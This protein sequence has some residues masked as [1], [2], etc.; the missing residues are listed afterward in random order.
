MI[1]ILLVLTLLVGQFLLPVLPIDNHVH[2]ADVKA[3]TN[4]S[5]QD[6]V[7]LHCWNWSFNNIKANMAKIASLGYTA[8]QTSPI[9]QAK[10]ATKG[11]SANDWWVYYQPAAFAIDNTGNSAL[12]TKAEFKSMCETAHQYGIKVIVDVV[13]NHMGNGNSG[14][15]IHSNVIADLRNESSCWHDINTN[16][17]NYYDRYNITQYCLDGVPDLNTSSTKVQNYVLNYLKECVDAGA[18]GFR[19]DAVKHIETPQDTYCASN[20]WPNV[21]NGVKAYDPD[22]Y[23]YGEVLFNADEGNSLPMSAYTKYFPVTD[24]SWSNSVRNNVVNSNNAGA[25]SHS[26][27]KDASAD[28]LVLWAESHDNYAGD[29]T[30]GVSVTNINKTWALVAARADAMALYLARPNSLGSQK[31]GDASVTGW[32]YPEVAA[33]NKFHTA[34]AG[35]TEYVS[36][37]NN[38]A[39]VER[40]TSG[41]VLVNC[42]GTSGS[43]NVTANAMANGTYKDQI[44]GN[45]FTVSGG[46]ITGNIGSTGI[47]VVYNAVECNHESHS[48]GGVCSSCGAQVSH[49]FVG[50][51][52]TCSVCGYTK[53]ADKTIYFENTAGWS[54]VNIYTWDS[55]DNTFS[56]GWPGTAMTKVSGNIYSYTVSGE[57]E[58]VIFNNGT[59]QTDDLSIPSDADLY[60]Y[61]TGKWSSYNTCSHSYTSTVKAATCTAAGSTT[62]TCSKCGD[63]YSETIA[64]LGHSYGTATVTKQPTCAAAG[65]KTSTCG[66]CGDTKTES[67]AALGHSWDTGTVT[68]APTCSAAGVKTFT[69]GTCG[70]T[71]TESVASTDHN[72]VN[73]TCSACGASTPTNRTV[74]FDNTSNWSTVYI[75]Y[76]SDANSAMTTW[77]GKAMSKVSGSIYGYTIPLDAQYV[78]FNNNSGTQTGD[79]TLSDSK[80]LYTYSTSAW[81]SYA[82]C[83][84]PSHNT[85]GNCTSCGLAVGH[86]YVDNT[87]SVCGYTKPAGIKI[88]FD[89]SSKNWSTVYIYTWDDDNVNYSGSWPGSAMTN[90]GDGIWSYT[91]EAGAVNVIFNNNNGTQTG[92]LTIPGSGYIYNG[93][94]WDVYEVCEHS[95]TGTVTKAPTCTA[96]GVKT[97]TC[98]KC[99][100]SYTESVGMIDHNY[101]NGTCSACGAV[102]PCD[103]IWG[104][105]T[106]T[107]AP[108]CIKSGVKTYTCSL[109]GESKTETVAALGH[110]FA[111]GKC[112]VCGVPENCTNH[113]WDE[114]QVIEEKTCW[115]PGTALYTCTV[116]G[117]TEERIIYPGHD[118][119]D[120]DII[121]APTCTTSGRQKRLCRN[122]TAVY[123]KTI[124]ALG[125]SYEKGAV[126]APTC[127]EDGY[128]AYT[129]TTC[130]A[131][132]N[133]DVV[134]HTGHKWSGNT[135]SACGTTCAHSL[136]DGICSKCGYGG[137]AY[138]DGVYEIANAAQLKW[139]AA[140]VNGGDNAINGKLVAD[141]DLNNATWTAIGSYCPDG[142]SNASLFY[143]G[144]FDGNGHTVSN[145]TVAGNDAVGLFGYTEMGT[146]KNLGVIN[147]NATGFYAGA[148]VG[149]ASTS[150]IINCYAKN[151][152]ITGYSNNPI[153]LNS[154]RV[155]VGA[156]A[157]QGSGYVYN[158]YAISCTL[159]D[160]TGS[161]TVP[162]GETYTPWHEFFATP[163]GGNGSSISNNYYYAVSGTFSSTT[164]ATEVSAAQLSSGEVTYL[165]NK[166]VTDGTQAWY[167]TCGV[168]MPAHSGKTV[169]AVT[170][171]GT[172]TTAYSNDSTASGGHN[173]GS[174]TTEPTCDKPGAITYTCTG[175]GHSYS[176]TIPAKGHAYSAVVTAPTCDNAGYTTNTCANCGN[177]YKSN[178]VAALGHNYVDGTCTNC[179]KADP[180][181]SV[182]LPTIIPGGGG[183]AFKDEIYYNVYFMVNNPDNV[184]IAETGVISWTSP[185]DGTIETAEHVSA[186]SV[187]QSNY[188]KARSNPISAKNMGE[189]L[190]M[191]VYA[192]L[193]DGTY[194]YSQLINYSAKTYAMNK[195]NDPASDNGLKALCVSLLN[196]G[197]SAQQYFGYKADD[198]MNKD[199]SAEAQALVSAYSD[200]MIPALVQPG[201]QVSGLTANGGFA[202]VAPSVNFGGALGI[203]YIAKVSKTVDSDVKLYVWTTAELAAN[204]ALTLENAKEVITMTA[205]GSNYSA[206]VGGIAAKNAGDT[207]YVCAV[208]ESN[209]VQYRTGVLT[210]SVSAY[211]KTYA[212]NA[213]S[214]FQPMAS[215]AAVYTYYANAYLGQ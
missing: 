122:C 163:V 26:Y 154:R 126:V 209:G 80:N 150:T 166:G 189:E 90:E 72:Y 10:Q 111:D 55:Y 146:I 118:L 44:T 201:S 193:A 50:T 113:V 103:H 109:C 130:G 129:C 168:G 99:G 71:K 157:G 48:I 139:F 17:S 132:E 60:T 117:E 75:Y 105:G 82:A 39:Y 141:I 3:A 175:C 12:G 176:E 13:A 214:S 74:Y 59:S 20:F 167:Q 63:T 124:P 140:K 41:A 98:S 61:S 204:E 121:Y 88:Y 145:F 68:T 85:S 147:A 186:G 210:Y 107:T 197:A 112:S 5:M 206:R 73:G 174:V 7:T 51:S 49:T 148:I 161:M 195:I 29:G 30:S 160:K 100:D 199:I 46:K 65:T 156:V 102:K 38:I 211:C 36:N 19:F 120:G 191:K 187:P 92:D 170:G 205:S 207:V 123:D 81:S 57:A 58:N 53:P 149:N 84:H 16:I 137:P 159:V 95:Y 152:T 64:A 24:N 1:G 202:G 153:A 34:F 131:T 203:N 40:G 6:G 89:N 4:L 45:T 172:G 25:F 144:T 158:C 32:S 83:A 183:L 110:S 143:R 155:Y 116:C 21:I 11:Y 47:A 87:C 77:P 134:F 178:E 8:I 78:I 18:D 35:Q 93:S 138:V 96:N 215:M 67:V 164:G 196:Y 180:D 208:Y 108:T 2:A 181:F 194:V 127:T 104:T 31:L 213:A 114:G 171:C 185:I 91:V 115:T 125:H 136:V 27:H 192:K 162:S 165:L 101:V 62:Y 200:S 212:N 66:T 9:Q 190:Y 151:C 28:Q 169:Y 22:V 128:T 179:G 14:S 119:Y 76:W 97:F 54:T 43:V 94:S 142:D 177:S 188:F 86:S 15:G 56:G 182:T 52:T 70:T 79:L 184:Q 23:C 135:C 198:L 133:R 106:V 173:Y 37:Q 33:V 42:G 69:C